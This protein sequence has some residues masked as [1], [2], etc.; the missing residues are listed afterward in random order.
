M[1]P[2]GLGKGG[3]GAPARPTAALEPVEG[4]RPAL[5]RLRA[6][7][8]PAAV[9]AAEREGEAVVAAG[10]TRSGGAKGEQARSHPLTAV[11]ASLWHNPRVLG[12]G[13]DRWVGANPPTSQC[14]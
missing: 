8:A 12:G 10:R 11:R 3:V 9:R 2:I 6:G 1:V 7:W 14:L 13:R 4:L 5:A